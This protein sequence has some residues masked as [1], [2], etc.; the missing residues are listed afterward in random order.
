M[1]HTVQV[2]LQ[3]MTKFSDRWKVACN[4]APEDHVQLLARQR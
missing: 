2:G 3:G 4:I 1:S